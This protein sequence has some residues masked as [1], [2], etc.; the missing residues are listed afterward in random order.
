MN[1]LAVERA[2]LLNLSR[3]EPVEEWRVYGSDSCY[4]MAKDATGKEIWQISGI[5][6]VR[7]VGNEKIRYDH[8]RYLA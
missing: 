2:E 7:Y 6:R 8:G 4:A 3:V 1:Y 5:V